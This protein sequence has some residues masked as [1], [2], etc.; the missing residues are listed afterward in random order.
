MNHRFSIDRVLTGAH[1]EAILPPEDWDLFKISL[2]PVALGS[3]NLA[4]TGLV[5]PGTELEK[6]DL[7]SLLQDIPEEIRDWVNLAVQ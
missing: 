7:V 2:E 1:Q 3:L 5:F 6:P 4:Y